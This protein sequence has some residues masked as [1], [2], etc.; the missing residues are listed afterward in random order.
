VGAS[1][2]RPSQPQPLP[3]EDPDSGALVQEF[4]RAAPGFAER[5]KGRFDDLDAVGFSQV[6]PGG[7][8]AEVGA[9]TGHFLSLFQ[10]VA[11]T[12]IA[13]DLTPAMLRQARR[14]H[15][16]VAP[17]IANGAH[18]PLR[19]SSVDL[20][21]SAQM[22][23]H[24]REPLP[25]LNEMRRVAMLGGKVLIVDQTA[26]E[27]FEEAVVMTELETVRDP[28]HAASRPPSVF[29][30]L[31]RAAG[32]DVVDERMVESR[33][34]LSKWMWPGEFPES[35]IEQVREFIENRGHETGM[36]FERDGDDFT[37]TRRRIMLL[38]SKPHL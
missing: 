37:F 17:V 34:H 19:S 24:V 14:D 16:G 15:A 1:S 30:L 20:V 5:T 4:T 36:D 25:I 29:R 38:A 7:V 6:S 35:R 13:I 2:A 23:H 18:L 28:S 33:S 32:L 10:D 21:A 12:L 3:E 9:G 26:P 27:K 8:V 11:S 31:V 22:F